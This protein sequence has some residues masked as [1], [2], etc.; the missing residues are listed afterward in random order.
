MRITRQLISLLLLVVG[1]MGSSPSGGAGDSLRSS[2]TGMVRLVNHTGSSGQSEGIS[3][4]V[5]WAVGRFERSGLSLPVTTIT[6][7]RTR[8]PCGGLVG[9]YRWASGQHWVRICVGGNRKREL[10]VLHELAHA[11][12]NDRMDA[13][14]RAS[15][16][17]RRALLRWN[18]AVD[19]WAERGAEQAAMIIA[20]G[21]DEHCQGPEDLPGED[22]QSLATEFWRLTGTHPICVT[23]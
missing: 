14:D 10:T 1:V 18:S 21:L 7:D 6:F 4:V 9:Y 3:E 15:F 11:F 12:A 22:H 20:W 8:S 23:P 5:S 16:L 2:A 17:S 19:A 13:D